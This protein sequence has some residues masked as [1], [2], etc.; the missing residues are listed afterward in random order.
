M[1]WQHLASLDRCE[2]DSKQELFMKNSG[3]TLIEVMIVVAIIAIVATIAMPSYQDYVAKTR[4]AEATGLLL[5]GAQALER[6]YSANG[7]Y[8]SAADTLAAVFPTQVPTNGA[9]YY[10]IA[11]TGTPTRATFTLRATRVAGGVMEE[12][13]CGD[14]QVDQAGQRTLNGNDVGKGVADCWRR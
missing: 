2:T 6:Y 10:T 7:T 11:A 5:E 9:A 12:D 3:F 8:L 4:R 1:P 14:L 13:A